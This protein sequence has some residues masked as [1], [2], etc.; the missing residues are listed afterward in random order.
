M[1]TPSDDLTGESDDD[2]YK[3]LDET[4]GPNT[5]D[6]AQEKNPQYFQGRQSNSIGN[7]N[8]SN[9]SNNSNENEDGD[10]WGSYS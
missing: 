10:E 5:V 9:G 8:N 6:R 3:F 7:N 2:F 1:A 4:F